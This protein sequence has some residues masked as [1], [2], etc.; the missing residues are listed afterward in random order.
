[1]ASQN[2]MDLTKLFIDP[3]TT[4]KDAGGMQFN[5]WVLGMVSRSGLSGSTI[6]ELN[7]MAGT[8]PGTRIPDARKIEIL[9][10]VEKAGISLDAYKHD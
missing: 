5:S 6:T 2:N 1:M 9:E 10:K 8:Y 3:N 4:A 7:Y